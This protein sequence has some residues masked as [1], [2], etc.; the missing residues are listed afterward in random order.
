MKEKYIT[1]VAIVVQTKLDGM[2]SYFD[3]PQI[4][5][6][7]DKIVDKHIKEMMKEIDELITSL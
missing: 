3:D 1:S 6:E 5:Y 2:F 4:D 7:K